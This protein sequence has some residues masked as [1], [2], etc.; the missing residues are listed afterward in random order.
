MPGGERRDRMARKRGLEALA[1]VPLFSH[2]TPRQ[3]GRVLE[4]SEEYVFDEGATLAKEDTPGETFFVMLEGEA[5][6]VRH[7]RTVAR[8]L[9]GDFFGEI[10]LLDG[11][12]R[13]A[14]VVAVTPIRALL[15]LGD[16]FRKLLIEEPK[17][18]VKILRELS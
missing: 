7:G 12:H 4:V 17:L 2:L 13:T 6:V 16:D 11:G 14:S 5:R 18:A 9:P 10:S 15:L 1:Q 3:L 8:L